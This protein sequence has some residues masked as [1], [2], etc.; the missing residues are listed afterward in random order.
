MPLLQDAN[1][2]APLTNK[3]DVD[4]IQDQITQSKIQT[5]EDI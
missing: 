1:T 5:K 4:T 2:Q 3:T